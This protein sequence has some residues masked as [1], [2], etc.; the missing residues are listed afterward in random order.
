MHEH[1][2]LRGSSNHPIV[3]SKVG[4]RGDPGPGTN[5]CRITGASKTNHFVV[6]TDEHF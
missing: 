4:L 5:Q 1:S 3:V 2:I 6:S